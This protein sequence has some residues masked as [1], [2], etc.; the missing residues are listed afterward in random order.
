MTRLI[1]N[2]LSCYTEM[3]D[4]WGKSDNLSSQTSLITGISFP[5]EIMQ[6]LLPLQIRPQI[7]RFHWI[8][9]LSVRVHGDKRSC[10]QANT[11]WALQHDHLRNAI[12]ISLYNI[13]DKNPWTQLWNIW[14][15][16]SESSL[17]TFNLVINTRVSSKCNTLLIN[18]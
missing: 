5:L 18:F 7:Y 1:D 16:S 8:N 9:K 11:Q 4:I 13:A 14:M 2:H 17:L 3:T 15:Q 10:W 12:N 6:D